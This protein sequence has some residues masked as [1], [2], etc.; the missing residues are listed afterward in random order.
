M[1][2]FK[3][4]IIFINT[5]FSENNA[6][7]QGLIGCHFEN[8]YRLNLGVNVFVKNIETKS[9]EVVTMAF[10]D[11]CS[12]P[13][14]KFFLSSLYKGAMGIFGLINDNRSY[15]I[16]RKQVNDI[17]ITTKMEVPYVLVLI[18]NESTAN[19]DL[20]QIEE[21]VEREGGILIKISE[22]DD[23]KVNDAVLELARRII[24]SNIYIPSA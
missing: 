2:S 7:V 3:L 17:R 18:E 13:S 22:A 1:Q 9:G 24:D 5:G 12:K 23:C 15:E 8:N 20:V 16:V 11:V 10:W 19:L 6:V 21:Q 14:F 4:K